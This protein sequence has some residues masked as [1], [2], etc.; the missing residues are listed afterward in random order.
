M[1]SYIIWALVVLRPLRMTI[2][3]AVRFMTTEETNIINTMSIPV[4]KIKPVPPIF[5]RT[6]LVPCPFRI[7]VKELLRNGVLKHYF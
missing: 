5:C 7:M 2:M 3:E 6:P 1:N 4:T